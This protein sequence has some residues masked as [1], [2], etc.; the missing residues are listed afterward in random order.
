[1]YSPEAGKGVCIGSG[2]VMKTIAPKSAMQ[3]S[4]WVAPIAAAMLGGSALAQSAPQPVYVPS[5]Q[6][7]PAY[8]PSPSY[9]LSEEQLDALTGSIA[10][11]PDPLIAEI[12]PAAT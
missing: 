2:A 6:A 11:Y 8:V 4:R 9:R 1:M 7:A 10:L 3:M 12:L 5:P